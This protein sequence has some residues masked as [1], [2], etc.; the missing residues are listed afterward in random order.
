M[1]TRFEE[2][3]IR[4]QST[5]ASM[6]IYLFHKDVLLDVMR[7][8]QG[9]NIGRDIFPLLIS[10]TTVST[11]H[12]QGYWADVGTLQAYYEASMALLTETPALELS[13]PNWIIHTKSAEMPAAEI[14]G[15]ALIGNSMICDGSRIAGNVFGSLIGPGVVI[16]AGT[17]II[18]SIILPNV[19]I[20][21][22]CH[23]ERTI[24]DKGAHIGANSR[25]GHK[26][27]GSPNRAY[28]TLL[29][30]GLT[31]IGMRAQVPAQAVVG[32]NVLIGPR[33]VPAQ[34]PT[35]ANLGD[36]ETIGWHK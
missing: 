29:N 35:P 9:E 10:E 1:V 18:D 15:S 2:K 31:V 24:I 14:A 28:P 11:Y 26:Q 25:I 33:I 13:D 12:F 23:I 19:T 16:P 36:G 21:A 7:R 32:T 27:I 3:P 22:G 30:T 6:G 8:H 34:W 20:E 5:L 17:T 4:S